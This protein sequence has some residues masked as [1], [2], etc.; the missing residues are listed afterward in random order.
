MPFAT[1]R[2]PGQHPAPPRP[3]LGAR[4]A[5]GAFPPTV[6]QGEA[7]YPGDAVAH[8]R[9]SLEDLLRPC[10]RVLVRVAGRDGGPDAVGPALRLFSDAQLRLARDMH[11]E[12]HPLHRLPAPHGDAEGG[13][14]GARGFVAI[15]G[16]R[17]A[18]TVDPG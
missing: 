8:H 17:A 6:G 14:H 16:N 4:A 1:H 10:H 12:W 7:G 9:S 5:D 13:P 15:A 2:P 3:C 18:R 11:R